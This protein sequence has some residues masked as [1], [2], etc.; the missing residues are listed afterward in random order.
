MQ[1]D[2]IRAG[3]SKPGL[4]RQHLTAL[5]AAVEVGDANVDGADIRSQS[6]YFAPKTIR[7]GRYHFAV[8]TAG[9]ATLVLQTV[10][11]ALC[12]ANGRSDIILEGGT[13][14]PWAPPYDFL[15]NAYFPL[16]Q[17]TGPKVSSG[18]EQYG[19]YPA[20]GGRFSVGVEPTNRLS[21]IE[22]L[23]RG[24]ITDRSVT[25][26]VANL[27][28]S[29]AQREI[30]VAA[31][32]LDWPPSCFHIRTERKSAGPGN[33]VMID[34]QSENVRELFT[35]FGRHG[36]RAENVAKDAIKQLRA[37]LAAEVPVGPYLAD[38][39][40]L[41]LSL[42]AWRDGDTSRF[43]TLALTQHSRTHIDVLQQFLSVRIEVDSAED[44]TCEVLI[45]QT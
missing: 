1:L 28:G 19:F 16:L 9:S 39:I 44:G 2:N 22:L 20:G 3:R 7:A 13:H 21:G 43:R 40:M 18:L 35:S 42:A 27:P 45:A 25:A 5:R 4:L 10:L 29:I 8:G 38:Q 30:D 6:V 14:N 12:I 24:R 11:P 34:V 36:V 31:R 32:R 26:L 15:A 17:Q 37:Y 33:V 41:P 23:D